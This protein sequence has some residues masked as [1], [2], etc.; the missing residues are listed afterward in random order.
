MVI[1]CVGET[2]N[3]VVDQVGQELLIVSSFKDELPS[4]FQLIIKA[5]KEKPDN[6]KLLIFFTTARQTG[7]V[8]EVAQSFFKNSSIFKNVNLF[9]IHSRKSQSSRNKVS[10]SFRKCHKGIM[11]SSDVSARGLD[12]PGV[13]HVIQVGAPLNREQYIHRLGRT[14]RAGESGRG[15]IML[16]S[17]EKYFLNEIKDLELNKWKLDSSSGQSK[18]IMHEVSKAVRGTAVSTREKCYQAWLGY[19]KGLLGKLKWSKEELVDQVNCYSKEV[20]GLDNQPKLQKSTIGKMGLKGI[21]GLL[22][23]EHTK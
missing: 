12:Y 16:Q 13:T 7:F 3:Q 8:S 2:K 19:Y 21:R 15:I 6:Y 18:N 22:I 14:A 5:I 23:G 1:D 20:L 9:E 4:L 11:F 17:F 10:D